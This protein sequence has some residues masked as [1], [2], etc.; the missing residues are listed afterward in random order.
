MTHK[1]DQF[2][3]WVILSNVVMSVEVCLNCYGY[4]RVYSPAAMVTQLLDERYSC[5]V[6]NHTSVTSVHHI[7]YLLVAVYCSI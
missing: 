5:T 4:R 1:I 6:S 3:Y 2:G 7:E